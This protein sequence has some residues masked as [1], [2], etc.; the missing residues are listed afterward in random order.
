M[1]LHRNLQWYRKVEL[2]GNISLRY[3]YKF[4]DRPLYEGKWYIKDH[5]TKT[6]QECNQQLAERMIK[7]YKDFYGFIVEQ[8]I[9]GYLD[10]DNKYIKLDLL[11]QKEIK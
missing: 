5:R 4:S 1:K 2:F 7:E 8:E 6:Y 9:V 3:F 10:N 11:E